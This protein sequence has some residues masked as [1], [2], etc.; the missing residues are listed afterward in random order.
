MNFRK[1]RTT[2]CRKEERDNL[3]ITMMNQQYPVAKSPTSWKKR[4]FG[5]RKHHHHHHDRKV[6]IGKDRVPSD[7][8]LCDVERRKK[9]KIKSRDDGGGG[10]VRENWR[11]HSTPDYVIADYIAATEMLMNES[12][13][14]SHPD[15]KMLSAPKLEDLGEA[16]DTEDRHHGHSRTN[17]TPATAF[18]FENIP[19]YNEL[20]TVKSRSIT[21]EETDK[22][23]ISMMKLPENKK[24]RKV[25]SKRFSKLLARKQSLQ[26]EESPLQSA[27]YNYDLATLE[28]LLCNN[29]NVDFDVNCLYTPGVSLLHQACVLGDINITTL[30][31]E[32]G[33]NVNLQTWNKMSPIKLATVYGHF[34]IAQYLISSGAYVHDIVNGSQFDAK[35]PKI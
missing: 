20:D 32:K 6:S 13:L 22:L 33:A 30:L 21:P 4:F 12:N 19:E 10:D 18:R 5:D 35:K 9:G 14:T 17:S 3:M 1:G 8:R 11:R 25:S 23:S 28:K 7:E 29:N 27:V 16:F 24:I 2:I 26:Y 34:D 31:V 15:Q